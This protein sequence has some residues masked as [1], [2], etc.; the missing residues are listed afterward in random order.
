[1][2]PDPYFLK[3][4][5]WLLWLYAVLF[6][7]PLEL[8]AQAATEAPSSQRVVSEVEKQSVSNQL[9][10][11][12]RR[13]QAENAPLNRKEYGYLS[14]LKSDPILCAAVQD[15]LVHLTS[16][17]TDIGAV[18]GKQLAFSYS[19]A[20]QVLEA[21]GP[22]GLPKIRAA[23]DASDIT[24]WQRLVL[25]EVE[26]LVERRRVEPLIWFQNQVRQPEW[27]FPVK[28]SPPTDPQQHVFVNWKGHPVTPIPWHSRL[29]LLATVIE[30]GWTRFKIPKQVIL[31]R[32][33]QRQP[34]ALWDV[35]DIRAEDPR[36]RPNDT[37]E[38]AP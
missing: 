6:S 8:V 27:L 38:V 33:G 15:E 14:K 24:P 25:Q 30:A 10:E 37:L 1:M 12:L 16:V 18:T 9:N 32:D 5:R 35:I 11:I 7:C 26:Q 13:C 19:P 28:A 17:R 29:T 20:G 34:I 21:I 4:N 3:T 36:M 2:S 22:A 23:L 31:L